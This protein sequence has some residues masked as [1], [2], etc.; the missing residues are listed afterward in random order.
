ML[1]VTLACI[2][3]GVAERCAAVAE[4]D[5]REEQLQRALLVELIGDHRR[6]LRAIHNGVP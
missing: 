1:I 5:D 3:I 6:D 2:G 4:T